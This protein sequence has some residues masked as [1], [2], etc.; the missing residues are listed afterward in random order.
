MGMRFRLFYN[1]SYYEKDEGSAI[2]K[3]KREDAE[4]MAEALADDTKSMELKVVGIVR[5]IENTM[6]ASM[7]SGGGIG[8]RRGLTSFLLNTVMQ[9]TIVQDQVSKRP[10][11]EADSEDERKGIDIFS[12]APFSPESKDVKELIRQI[13]ES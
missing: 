9:S 3:D 6:A 12:G 2:W 4:Y 1:T 11:P 10:N 8:Y 7:F 5:T 13:R